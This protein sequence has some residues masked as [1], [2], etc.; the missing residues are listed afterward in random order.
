MP[1]KKKVQAHDPLTDKLLRRVG[2]YRSL[3]KYGS[4]K[5]PDFP[6]LKIRDNH[7]ERYP[8]VGGFAVTLPRPRKPPADAVT[9]PVGQSHKQGYMLWT[10]F[11]DPANAGGSKT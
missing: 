11:D 2:Y 7:R 4:S 6:D 5:G 10:S 3:E 1:R 8:S 9:F